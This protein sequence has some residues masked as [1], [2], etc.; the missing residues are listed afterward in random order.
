MESLRI[1]RV[2]LVHGL[3]ISAYAYLFPLLC[4][5]S[6]TSKSNQCGSNN[7]KRT[8]SQYAAIYQALAV[9]VSR[10]DDVSSAYYLLMIILYD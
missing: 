6:S 3:E 9:L 5:L 8:I 1:W 4:G 2:C 7:T 10:H